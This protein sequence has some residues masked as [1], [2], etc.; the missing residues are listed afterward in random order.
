MYPSP[1]DFMSPA[2]LAAWFVHRRAGRPDQLCAGTGWSLLRD[3]HQLEDAVV[4]VAAD[5]LASSSTPPA[6]PQLAA[7]IAVTTIES[8]VHR[9]VASDRPLD[10]DRFEAEVTRMVTGYLTAAA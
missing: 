10:T 7:R 3:L 9:M 4:D 8:L 2:P 5:V 1:S 6:E